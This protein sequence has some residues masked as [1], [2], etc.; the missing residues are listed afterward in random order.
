MISKPNFTVP[1][2]AMVLAAGLGE[3]MRPLTQTTPKPLLEVGGQTMLDHALN[4]LEDAGVTDV[5]VNTHWLAEKIENHLKGRKGQRIEISREEKLLETG[6]GVNE[7]LSLLANAPFYVINADI[8]WR[9]GTVPAL[10]RLA[11][12]WDGDSMDALLLLAATVRS[13]GY[14]G[15]GDFLMDSAGGLT[16]R[17][18]R[19]VAPFVFTGVQ[20]V[21]P[22]LFLGEPNDAFSI[23]MLYDRIL[24]KGRLSGIVHDGDWYHVGTPDAI[25][26]ADAEILER[27]GSR[28]RLLF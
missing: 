2:H 4:R 24:K 13:T 28:V 16:R 11:R 18:E 10:H 6:G 9:D 14:D 15:S 8:V 19:T 20:I 21:H 26:T 23:N 7:A 1:D 22:R 5:V 3:R 17:P 27:E 12:E 25:D